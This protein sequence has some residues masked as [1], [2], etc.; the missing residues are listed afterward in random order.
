M[1]KNLH[2]LIAD[3][4][5][6]QHA[7]SDNK[8]YGYH[9][10]VDPKIHNGKSMRKDSPMHDDD[11]A[12]DHHYKKM[13]QTVRSLTGEHPKVVKHYLDSKHGRHLAD[14]HNDNTTRRLAVSHVHNYIKKDFAKFKKHYKP[15]LFETEL[16]DDGTDLQLDEAR[17]DH[18][19]AAT[20][21]VIHPDSAQ[22]AKVGQHAD[23]YSKKNGDKLYGKVTHNDGKEVH[24]HHE[25]K[26]HKFKVKRSYEGLHEEEEQLDEISQELRKNYVDAARKDAEQKHKEGDQEEKRGQHLASAAS[27]AK[28]NDRSQKAY[29]AAQ[30]LKE[31]EEVEEL[32]EMSDAGSFSAGDKVIVKTP[33]SPHNNKRG[34]YVG[35][36]RGRHVVKHADGSRSIHGSGALLKES[37]A[38]RVKALIKE[39]MKSA[40]KKPETVRTANGK[41]ITKMV[42]RKTDLA[43]SG[44]KDGGNETENKVS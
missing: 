10:T 37:M 36:E 32:E 13:H 6:S 43:D 4:M 5:E 44:G 25:G 34:T 23:F 24:F 7:I 2:T 14:V 41:L 21:G 9:G 35:V 39:E 19:E 30:K 31:D 16:R 42:T 11:H 1:N 17:F 29:Q 38:S 12:R 28:A 15:D 22:H 40:D 8:G 26:T 18:R 33:N 27:R 20:H 3:L